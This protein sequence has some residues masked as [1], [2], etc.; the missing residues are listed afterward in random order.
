[1]KSEYQRWYVF[2]LCFYNLQTQQEKGCIACQ[3][4]VPENVE[5]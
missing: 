1:M 3:P 4:L 2:R 5:P